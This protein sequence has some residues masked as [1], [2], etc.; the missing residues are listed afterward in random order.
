MPRKQTERKRRV[1]TRS[2]NGCVT[3]KSK[4]LRCDEQ[5]PLCGRCLSSGGSCG[6][7]D[8]TA[9]N[10]QSPQPSDGPITPKLEDLELWNDC[11]SLTNMPS[12]SPIDFPYEASHD[13]GLLF[14]IFSRYRSVV[15][16]E[17]KPNSH[18]FL[19]ERT[20]SS[21]ALLHG[22]LL[23][24]AL[25]WTW[26]SGSNED[27]EKA[28]A[29][30]QMEAI[31]F[32]NDRL[33][34]PTLVDSDTTTAGIAALAMAESGFG[35]PDTAH[36]HLHSL[37]QVLATQLPISDGNGALLYNM[38]VCTTQGLSQMSM[39]EVFLMQQ[40]I[41]EC[42]TTLTLFI[43]PELQ[44][45]AE[46]PTSWNTSLGDMISTR[47][48]HDRI[49]GMAPRSEAESRARFLQC[50]L[51]V[52][53]MLGPDNLD[54]FTLNWFI[55]ALIDELSMSESAMLR[56]TFPRQAWLWA[57]LMARAAVTSARHQSL[58]EAQQADEWKALTNRN[59]RIVSE[60]SNLGTW[61]DAETLLRTWVWRGNNLFDAEPLREI[62]EAAMIGSRTRQ[63]SDGTISP[64]FLDKRLC[65]FGNE[66]KPVIMDDEAFD[67]CVPTVWT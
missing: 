36:A 24:S 60:A 40:S 66:K 64:S 21:P 19:V 39:Q 17:V 15:D 27:I 45:L 50:C 62:W 32:V 14:N 54:F 4:H 51:R 47:T 7:V 18:V 53:T 11:L 30:H 56:G 34:N 12:Q 43:D 48:Y 22:A 33:Q 46:D 37:S 55:E 25:R 23:L 61:T 52:V 29:H 65:Y 35:H 41:T 13:H 2:R 5:K 6:Y 57:A 28:V 1:H 16:R 38:T 44:R 8:R 10:S 26:Y 63:V 9:Q 31:K 3:C 49:D 67:L 20:L 58:S 42:V 59:I